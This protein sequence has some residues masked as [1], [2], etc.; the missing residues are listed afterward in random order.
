MSTPHGA[1]A[2]AASCF[3]QVF[4]MQQAGICGHGKKL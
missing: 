2:S 3:K 4:F 1:K